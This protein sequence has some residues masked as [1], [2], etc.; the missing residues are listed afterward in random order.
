MW[1]SR[2]QDLIASPGHDS[3]G[4]EGACAQVLRHRAQRHVADVVKRLIA[5]LRPD[6]T[7]I[8]G[9]NVA[10]LQ[11]CRRVVAWART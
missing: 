11:A 5:A 7:V 8:G 9:G 6:D 10:E 2:T 3:P 1:N 4:P